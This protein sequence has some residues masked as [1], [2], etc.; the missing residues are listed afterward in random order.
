MGWD[1]FRDAWNNE[2][3]FPMFLGI[4]VGGIGW[5]V[6]GLALTL[7]SEVRRWLGARCRG[8]QDG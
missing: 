1:A 8:G 6:W 2:P 4:A 5:L 3:G 7:C